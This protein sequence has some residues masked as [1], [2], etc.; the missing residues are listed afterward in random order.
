MLYAGVLLPLS[1]SDFY[2]Y[3]VPQE[4][5]AK[6][7]VGMR[8]V[9]QFGAKR[10]YVGII[11]S[12]SPTLPLGVETHKVKSLGY[13]P[14][15]AP[16]ISQEE[17]D[18]WLWAAY[19]YMATPGDLLHAA[20]PATLLPESRTEVLIDFEQADS[21]ASLG[22]T[23]SEV[24]EHLRSITG[25]GIHF[26]TLLQYI[27]GRN[28]L[29][30]FDQLVA[31][32]VLSLKER[33]RGVEKRIGERW[34]YLNPKYQSDDALNLL[35]DAYKRRPAQT[36]LLYRFVE[37]LPDQEH[38]LSG[39][40]REK[41]LIAGDSNRQNA[42]RYLLSEGVLER[43][44]RQYASTDRPPEYQIDPNLPPLESDRPNYYTAATYSDE[45]ERIGAYSAAVLARGGRVLLLLPQSSG[46]EG[47]LPSLCSQLK[48]PVETPLYLYT[49]SLS[50]RERASLRYRLTESDAPLIVVGSRMAA[51]L[52]LEG[53]E[54]IIVAEEQDPLYKQQEP[55]PRFN[56]RDLLAYRATKGKI[57]LLLTSVT[58]SMETYHN[59][60]N[61]KY[62]AIASQESFT[63][64]SFRTIDLDYEH[65]TRRLKTG[66]LLSLPLRE[67]ISETLKKG[68][69]VVLV[70]ARRGYA[71]YILCQKCGKSI[72]CLH[73]DVSL[74]YHQME[75]RLACHYCGYNLSLPVQCP[76]CGADREE[77]KKVGYG[78]ERIEDELATLYPEEEIVRIDADTTSGKEKRSHIRSALAEGK[79]SLYVGT[80]M[81]THFAPIQGV[82]LVAVP[83]LDAMLALPD[84][85]TDELVFALLYRLAVKY[86][87]ALMLL[88]T[89]DTQRP[90]FEYL[91]MPSREL[92][93]KYAE[94][95]LQERTFFGFPP[96]ERIIQVIVKST[97]EEDAIETATLL[98]RLFGSYPGLA[99][100]SAPIKPYVSRVRLMYI[101]QIT[102]KL[103][104]NYSAKQIREALKSILHQVERTSLSAR[105]SRILFDV[106]PL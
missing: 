100:V 75:N 73:C 54:L 17:I 16:I 106:D 30:V 44:F 102:L 48:L 2:H 14:D 46:L 27:P 90:L 55:A 21:D 83:Q 20:L 6:V 11:A 39:S 68:E 64:A 72:R 52:P 22:R 104:P 89:S 26:E 95:V 65:T 58:P 40:V 7:R 81:L 42:L 24:V 43:S 79:A 63:L 87:E 5:E 61:D 28:K 70:S 92:R 86:P 1:L 67:A 15:D 35:L 101:R 8:C 32:G 31:H 3:R 33:V 57:P 76:H 23:E 78:S 66:T 60:A 53:V 94:L 51:L 88:Q 12:L 38:S 91:D 93:E 98:S 19:Y 69:K 49:S 96:Y 34:L 9:V 105:R 37:L 84:F 77:L 18:S 56:A 80:Q 99:H 50:D 13:L 47:D 103:S 97:R 41:E 25:K 59:V 10:I 29:S 36:R 85:R 4:L 74:T 62:A 45:L 82:G 71:P